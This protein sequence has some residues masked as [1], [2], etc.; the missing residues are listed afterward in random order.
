MSLCQISNSGSHTHVMCLLLA[1]VC[2][3]GACAKR[4]AGPEAAPAGEA[5]GPDAE[6]AEL[7]RA[8]RELQDRANTMELQLL[9]KDAQVREL[10]QR[11]EDQQRM[12]DE[13]ISEVVRAKAKL[14]SVESKAE[15]AS[16]IAETEIALK[17]LS[18]RSGG[19]DTP[20]YRQAS[21]LLGM[22][23]DE[24]DKDNY[25]GAIYLTSQA[26]TLI[27][28]G[29]LRLSERAEIETVAGAVPFGV[30]LSL[31]VVTNSNVREG[32]GLSF[33]VLTTLKS[34]APV[35][36]HSHKGKWVQVQLEDGT[37]GWIHQTLVG[38]R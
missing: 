22:S 2:L 24:F 7:E 11:L 17:A 27:R 25:G 1:A 32:P 14:R 37:R 10:Q 38:S 13:T 12:L 6:R 35:T 30:P 20:E 36:A 15:A 23:A 29:Q 28:T 3:T 26:K 9:E 5:A 19:A 18:D 31:K 34:G 33:R 21:E 16:A 4:P 8:H